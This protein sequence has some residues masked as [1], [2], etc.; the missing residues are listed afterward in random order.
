MKLGPCKSVSP[1]VDHLSIVLKIFFSLCWTVASQHSEG[2]YLTTRLL[3][4]FLL[5]KI[6]FPKVTQ[7][8][9]FFKELSSVLICNSTKS[10]HY[11]MYSFWVTGP[12]SFNYLVY[13]IY[14]LCWVNTENI[15]YPN[16]FQFMIIQITSTILKLQIIYQSKYFL[17]M[18]SHVSGH[19]SRVKNQVCAELLP[20]FLPE[21]L[22]V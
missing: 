3:C 21:N 15:T 11:H 13:M 10:N 8:S 6:L 14:I 2:S 16:I 19:I 4:W 22:S 5:V 17:H 20:K 9:C 18:Y 12:K 7:A 1:Y